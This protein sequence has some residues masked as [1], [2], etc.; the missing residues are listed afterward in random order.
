VEIQTEGF[1]LKVVN[2]ISPSD[3]M[4]Y[5]FEFID[6]GYCLQTSPLNGT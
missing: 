1:E 5:S 3:Q 6:V 2:L 4:P